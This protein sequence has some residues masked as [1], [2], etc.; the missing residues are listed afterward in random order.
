MYT[1]FFFLKKLRTDLKRSSENEETWWC[2]RQ[3]RQML[4]P[5]P[6]LETEAH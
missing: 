5:G 4:L 6:Q 1:L 2:W 3:T